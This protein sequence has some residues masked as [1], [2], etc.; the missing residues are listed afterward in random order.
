[1]PLTVKHLA[2]DAHEGG[3]DRRLAEIDKYLTD[4]QKAEVIST[5]ESKTSSMTITK[6]V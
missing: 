1:M 2:S 4:A 5:S 6:G 3:E